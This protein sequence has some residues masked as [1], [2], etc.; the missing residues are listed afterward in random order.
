[1]NTCTLYYVFQRSQTNYASY[2]FYFS[3]QKSSHLYSK[4][5]EIYRTLADH[6]KKRYLSPEEEFG[7]R[8]DRY[9]VKKNSLSFGLWCLTIFQ[10]YHGCQ[11]YWWMK[12]EY[13]EKTTNLSQVTDK[14]YLIMLY[15]VTLVMSGVRTHNFSGERQI[16][17]VY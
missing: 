11:F 8:S 16:H 10:L 9:F 15:R 2:Y 13:P 7:H 12:P 5:Y 3:V 1:M 14:L 17:C 4:I 6:R